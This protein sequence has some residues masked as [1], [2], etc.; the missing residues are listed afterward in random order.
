MDSTAFL[1]I[2]TSVCAALFPS[3]DLTVISTVSDLFETACSTRLS[4]TFSDIVAVTFEMSSP[5]SFLTV[6]VLVS[7]TVV[8][9][10]ISDVVLSVVVFTSSSSAAGGI[11]APPPVVPPPVFSYGATTYVEKCL[12]VNLSLP[13][14]YVLDIKVLLP[15]SS[16]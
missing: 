15:F 13:F 7:L 6:S 9:V 8:L 12:A 14:S 11:T 1:E 4:A 16:I 10:F 2:S 5:C 3:F